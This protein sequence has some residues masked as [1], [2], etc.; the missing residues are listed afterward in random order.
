MSALP[1]PSADPVRFTLR[2]R[3]HECDPQGVVFNA[4]YLAYADMAS[5]ELWRALCG[6]Y[7]A[8]LDRGVDSV[9]AAS[10]TRHLGAARYDDELELA[11]DVTHV[12]TTSF[13]FTTAI[14]R[15]GEPIAEIRVRHVFL[16]FET[17]RKL[18]PPADVRA[19][20]LAR[21]DGGA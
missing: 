4:N 19:L 6:S 1:P 10:Q 20:L 7:Q 21:L 13:E 18:E 16:D 14:T 17:R 5:F 3:Y 9:V 2:V 12:G 11:V 8:M 15:D